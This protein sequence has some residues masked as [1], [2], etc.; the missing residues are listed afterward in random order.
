M[1][2]RIRYIRFPIIFFLTLAPLL[3]ATHSLSLPDNDKATGSKVFSLLDQKKLSFQHAYSFIF[4]TDGSS[5]YYNS[6][7]LNTLQYQL[8]SPLRLRIKWGISLT[9]GSLTTTHDQL[10][11]RGSLKERLILPGFELLYHP[12]DNFLF[13]V[14]YSSMSL[15]TR[16]FLGSHYLE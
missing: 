5:S 2:I 1:A 13:R 10:P 8:A 11:V 12:A 4:N 3:G 15:P 14:Q 6:F 16:H 9:P 7:Y